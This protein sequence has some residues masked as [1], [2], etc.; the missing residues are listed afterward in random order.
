M[1]S[2]A[3]FGGMIADR[4]R[5]DAHAAALRRVVTPTSVVLDIGAGTGI[6]SLLACKAGARR[7]YA[8]EPS[9][10]V[11]ILAA[12]ARDNGFADRVVVLQQRST[13]VTLPERADVIISDLRGVLPP[14][15]S[16]FADIEDARRRLLAPG[17]RLLPTRDILCLAVISAP[18]AFER[19][20]DV[21][22]SAP[23]GLDLRSALPFVDNTIAKCRARSDQL[24]CR[25]VT[26]A[27]VHYPSLA[28]RAVRGSGD[29]AITRDERAHGLLVWFDTELVDGIGYSNAPGA[30]DGIYGQIFFTW[31]EAVALR[32]GDR[33]AFEVRA[34][35]IGSD[36]L[37]TWATEINRGS[38]AA[39]AAVTRFRQS[40]FN[41]SPPS[42]ES[43]S[44]RGPAFAPGLSPG[45]IETL[46]VLEGMRAG[47]TI[48]ELSRQLLAAHPQRF[49]SP[50][51]AHGFVA[52]IVERYGSAR[53]PT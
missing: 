6:M 2:L 18:D 10:A 46:E 7:V 33:V 28:G 16:H 1:F 48:G 11:Q 47:R 25:P 34:D 44:R 40:T 50:D 29:C 5:I 17:G 21:W 3:D 26:W 35:P 37:W 12:A 43:L 30:A 39:A 52:E 36:Y 49:P 24:L 13:D 42:R 9:G 27:S 51:H 20:R 31:P 22:R 19:A 45:G 14:Y 38:G 32:A 15:G 4:V 8:V 41:S 23:Q 53:R